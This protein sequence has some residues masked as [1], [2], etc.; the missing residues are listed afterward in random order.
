MVT[1]PFL[2][3]TSS[4]CLDHVPAISAVQYE[5]RNVV[6][7]V[8]HTVRDREVASSS[9][10]IPTD[11]SP[12]IRRTGPCL[13]PMNHSSDI[14]PSID[15]P[16]PLV[17]LLDVDGVVNHAERFSDRYAQEHHIP[18]N[19]MSQFFEG[20][21]QDCV[22]G[23]ADLKKELTNV[24]DAWKWE[25][26]VDDLLDYW[27][28]YEIHFDKRVLDM[29]RILRECGVRV[30]GASNQERYRADYLLGQTELKDYFDGFFIS[31][32][33]GVKKPD[34]E[35]FQKVVDIIGAP[36]S[37]II[38]WDDD[39]ENVE[40]AKKLGIQSYVYTDFPTFQRQIDL[41]FSK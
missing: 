5:R 36:S 8:E 17:L 34:L 41:H 22:I 29:I 23:N 38:F 33:L 3:N 20:A 19:I 7:M 21:F 1:F 35:F 12:P 14:N 24:L 25:K 15:Q 18:P 2:N 26:S 6:Q 4:L 37:N 31:S 13:S 30:Y 40:G 9:L 16:H 32:Y 39:K 28:A 11:G 10:A 27:F